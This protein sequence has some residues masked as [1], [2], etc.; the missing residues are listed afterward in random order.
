MRPESFCLRL[1]SPPRNA[2]VQSPTSA[3]LCEVAM[4]LPIPVRHLVVLTGVEAKAPLLT[5]MQEAAA[6]YCAA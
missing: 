4:Q 1:R 5:A 6:P 2:M 3:K